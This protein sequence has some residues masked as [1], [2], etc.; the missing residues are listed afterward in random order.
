MPQQMM[1]KEEKHFWLGQDLASGK[2]LELGVPPEDVQMEEMGK[3]V[4]WGPA[5]EPA[6]QGL[7]LALLTEA[8]IEESGTVLA[9]KDGATAHDDAMV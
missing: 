5:I 6:P 1:D 4:M 8:P 3:R 9:Q 2:T 7:P